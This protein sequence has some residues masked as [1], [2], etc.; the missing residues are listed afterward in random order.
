M[1]P[2]YFEAL[3]VGSLLLAQQCIDL[4]CLGFSGEN[5]LIFSSKNE[6]LN[7]IDNFYKDPE[8]YAEIKR[9]G[10]Y[11]IRERHKISDRIKLLRYHLDRKNE[12]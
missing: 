3:A 12:L 4:E 1:T 6:F 10:L 7:I 9:N 8:H 11:L 5:C 2:K